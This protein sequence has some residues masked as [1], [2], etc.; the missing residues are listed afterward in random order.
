MA[1]KTTQPANPFRYDLGGRP[2]IF[3]D[4]KDLIEVAQAYFKWVEDNPIETVDY[5]GKDATPVILYN[6]RAMTVEGFCNYAAINADTFYEY[7]KREGFTE[8]CTRIR[9]V[10][11]AQKFEGAAAGTLNHSIIARELGL[12]EHVDHTTKDDPIPDVFIIGGKTITMDG[13]SG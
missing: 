9:Q 3:Q 5:R 2:R 10:M 11:F 1:K 12:K 4:P 6:P 8:I 7:A 13:A